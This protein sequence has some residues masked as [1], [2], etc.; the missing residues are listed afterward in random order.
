LSCL[1]IGLHRTTRLPMD[2]FVWNLIFEYF[3]KTIK[4]IQVSLKSVKNN[5]YFTWGLLDIFCSYLAYFFLEWEIF[6][7]KVVEEIKTHILC[8][9]TVF[10]ELY[11][12][13]V[14]W[15]NTVQQGR[16][17]MTIWR[18]HVACRIPKATH[19]FSPYIILNAFPLQQWLQQCAVVLG[20]T[21]IACLVSLQKVCAIIS[22]MFTN[23]FMKCICW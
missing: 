23:K 1:S 15:K 17:Q 7:R 3:S 5:G 4:K 6:Q 8:S 11:C 22:I 10:R 9:T 21:Y 18:M 16:L 12:L 2:G 13:W 20:Y 14:M 19:T